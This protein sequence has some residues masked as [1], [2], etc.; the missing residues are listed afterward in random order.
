MPP[1]PRGPRSVYR[2]P[3]STEGAVAPGAVGT[4]KNGLESSGSFTWG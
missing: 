2:S 3:G 4:D 1:D